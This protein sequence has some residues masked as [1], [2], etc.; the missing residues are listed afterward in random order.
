MNIIF[1]TAVGIT[2]AVAINN[3]RRT[4]DFIRKNKLIG[5]LF[6]V[7]I[8]I[9]LHGIL[10]FLP[11]TYPITPWL[12][13]ILSLGIIIYLVIRSKWSEYVIILECFLGAILPDIID[14]GPSLVNKYMGT[15][16]SE[17]TLFP[18]HLTGR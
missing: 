12:D 16:F 15:S 11:H 3:N 10:D 14:L 8:N 4:S 18:W 5:L 1:H 17:I 13:I 2:S 7:F 6:C 9:L